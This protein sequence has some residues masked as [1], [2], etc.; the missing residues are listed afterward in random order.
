MSSC[1][2]EILIVVGGITGAICLIILPIWLHI[3]YPHLIEYHPC[4]VD[5]SEL[6]SKYADGKKS[7]LFVG[8]NESVRQSRTDEIATQDEKEAK[9]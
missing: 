2:L 9:I 7:K 8:S 6:W 1:L 3:K 4:C 5:Y